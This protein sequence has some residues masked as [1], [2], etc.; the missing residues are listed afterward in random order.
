MLLVLAVT[1]CQA[2]D[3]TDEAVQAAVSEQTDQLRAQLQ[4]GVDPNQVIARVSAAGECRLS[5]QTAQVLIDAGAQPHWC[6]LDYAIKQDI[7]LVEKILNRQKHRM[8]TLA[9]TAIESQNAALYELS[10]AYTSPSQLPTRL[11]EVLDA[12]WVDGI[13]VAARQHAQ[14]YPAL[15][16]AHTTER[17]FSAETRRL[18]VPP[19]LAAGFRCDIVCAGNVGQLGDRLLVR[20]LWEHGLR[21]HKQTAIDSA[22]LIR[23]T[24][25]AEFLD[26]HPQDLD[27][28]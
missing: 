2:A 25:M 11:R 28:P 27:P 20:Q 8:S 3:A 16:L 24:E 12:G 15:A 6:L 22:G 18:V 17:S 7:R 9:K 14:L 23:D 5:H 21:E 4:N 19:L 1:A 10:L 13:R 26:A